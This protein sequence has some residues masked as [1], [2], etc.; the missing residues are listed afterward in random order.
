MIQS[1]VLVDYEKF[2]SA[3]VALFVDVGEPKRSWRL[4]ETHGGGIERLA[5]MFNARIFL[6]EEQKLDSELILEMDVADAW[7]LLVANGEKRSMTTR[8]N[9]HR[10]NL[11]G[12]GDWLG[13][14]FRE[15]IRQIKEST[16]I[17]EQVTGYYSRLVT[18]RQSEVHSLAGET[19]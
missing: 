17:Q 5:R 16:Q 10:V 2:R 6:A 12:Q 7:L 11:E 4:L 15:L 19:N 3:R 18:P 1:Q 13:Y 9:P 8:N 14:A